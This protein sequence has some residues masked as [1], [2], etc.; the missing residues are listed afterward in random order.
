MP[1]LLGSSRHVEVGQEWASLHGGQYDLFR[2]V[3]VLEGRYLRKPD[4]AI[5]PTEF[6]RVEWLTG[7][8]RGQTT[9]QRAPDH[10]LGRGG[11]HVLYRLPDGTLTDWAERKE[12]ERK[13]HEPCPTCGHR[14]FA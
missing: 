3:E 5:I 7:R 1:S 11:S 8:L 14:S 10:I 9:D 12:A 6:C 2:V 4:A 13:R